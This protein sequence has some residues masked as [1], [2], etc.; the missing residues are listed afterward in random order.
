VIVTD[1]DDAAGA[2]IAARIGARYER[3]DVRREDDWTRVVDETLAR[4][5][6]DVVIAN[7]GVT[8]F[9]PPAGPHDPEHATLDAWRAVHA[10]NLDGVF[11]AC[12]HG[13]RALR[14]RGGSIVAVASRSGKVGVPRAA[15][16]ASSKAA[17]INHVR[18]VAL[19]C[20]QMNYPIRC[21]AVTPAA[22]RTPMCDSMLG[23]DDDGRADRERA[24]LANVPVGRFGTPDEVASA[25]L[26]LASPG[27]SYVTGA[28]LAIDGG[29]TAS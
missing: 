13:I 18:S 7:A 12:K 20:A 16:Y 21:N 1:I 14:E 24:I 27:A 6:L 4:D 29:V 25:V 10:V 5:G 19:Y 23:A 9:D 26:W 2:A 11:L 8:G 17:V 15:A 28:D 22:V 3:L